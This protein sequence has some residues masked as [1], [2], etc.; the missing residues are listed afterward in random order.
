RLGTCELLVEDR[1][2][3]AIDLDT[4]RIIDRY[5]RAKLLAKPLKNGDS[6]CGMAGEP[7][8]SHDVGFRVCKRTYHRDR[9]NGFLQRENGRLVTQKHS[10]SFSCHSR[11]VA[12]CCRIQLCLRMIERGIRIR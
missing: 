12:L 8:R 7:P 10:T 5:R 11:R 9:C 3:D 2:L 6:V 4:F 1:W